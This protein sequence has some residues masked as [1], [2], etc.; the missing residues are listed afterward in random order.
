MYVAQ[1]TKQRE[2]ARKRA[3]RAEAERQKRND[4]KVA[5]AKA[6]ADKEVEAKQEK[7]RLAKKEFDIKKKAAAAK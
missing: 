2:E 7:N 1:K 6:K 5:A 3:D 4:E